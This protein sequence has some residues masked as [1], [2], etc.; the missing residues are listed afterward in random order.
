MAG[1]V[2]LAVV[3][4]LLLQAP[5]VFAGQVGADA[6]A[7]WVPAI[8]LNAD[9]RLDGLALMFALLISGIGVLIVIYA[10]STSAPDGTRRASSSA[11]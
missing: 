4:V 7:E 10:A 6:G 8:G 9:L 3:A 1:G 2:A 5:M 11:S